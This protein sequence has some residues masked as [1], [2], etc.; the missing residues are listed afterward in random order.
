MRELEIK[1]QVH[2][3]QA[4]LK[5]LSELPVTMDEQFRQQDIVYAQI[6]RD[7]DHSKNSWLRI[8]NENGKHIFTLKR[9][10]TNE[11]D[12]IEHE[13]EVS[14]PEELEKIIILLGFQEHSAID[15]TRQKAVHK[16]VEICIDEVTG[17]GTFVEAEA[18]VEDTANYEKTYDE[19]WR[20]FKELGIDKSDEVNKGYDVLIR[21]KAAARNE[22]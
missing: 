14:N 18:M 5:K 2:N 3:K 17:L 20:L 6:D 16:D 11:L 4:L 21:E 1:A 12:N 15:K 9:A 10:V 8:R 13:T 7:P 22:A 19:L